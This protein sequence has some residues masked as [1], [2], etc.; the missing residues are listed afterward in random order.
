MIK[1]LRGEASGVDEAAGEDTEHRIHFGL[2][3]FKDGYHFDRVSDK[4]VFSHST[5][6]L[7]GGCVEADLPAEELVARAEPPV[8]RVGLGGETGLQPRGS[9]HL[10]T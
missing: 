1:C 5:D 6:G 8:E 9:G 7:D 4:P 10:S 3:V 2:A